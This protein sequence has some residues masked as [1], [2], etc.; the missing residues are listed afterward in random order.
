MV[1]KIGERTCA[2]LRPGWSGRRW[3][4]DFERSCSPVLPTT[5]RSER[6]GRHGIRWS[7]IVLTFRSRTRCPGHG[8][9]P[10]RRHAERHCH[11]ASSPS[12]F[13]GGE[14]APARA[15]MTPVEPRAVAVGEARTAA[16]DGP[17]GASGM[18]AST[19]TRL[20]ASH[21]RHG[22][23]RWTGTHT[24]RTRTST[25]ISRISAPRSGSPGSR[26]TSSIRAGPSTSRA[27]G[28][29]TALTE[30]PSLRTTCSPIETGWRARTPRFPQW[31]PTPVESPAQRT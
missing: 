28:S 11:T 26:T 25:T 30:P 9:E 29:R 13:D 21:D 5:P 8:I 18:I 15:A 3:I 22:E 2:G 4:G 24:T 1:G 23:H 10:R 12:R 27:R 14:V 16:G 7:P 20:R 19:R 31:V 17:T 6:G